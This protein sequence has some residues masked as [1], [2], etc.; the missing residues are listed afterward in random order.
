MRDESGG[1]AAG[2]HAMVP[3]PNDEA[4]LDT[5]LSGWRP[6][7]V[8]WDF[9][10]VLVDTL[11]V[12]AEAWRMLLEARGL[13]FRADRYYAACGRAPEDVALALVNGQMPTPSR[14]WLKEFVQE[15]RVVFFGLL[16]DRTVP[17]LDGVMLWL[18]TIRTAGI[19][20]AIASSTT[21]RIVQAI[22]S[23]LP[24]DRYF[25]AVVTNEDVPAC[26]PAPDVFLEA[27]ARL[28][29]AP[30]GCLVVEDSAHGV[31]AARAAQMKCLAVSCSVGPA[32][33]SCAHV[34]VATLAAADA[35]RLL[36]SFC[37]GA[38]V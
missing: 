10:G 21:Q 30:G 31:Q 38:G 24:V 37:A 32:E 33:L 8:L 36:R 34:T 13:G 29:V 25:S 12:H 22:L 28:G 20:Q 23:G 1:Q 7:A 15:E 19:P 5:G 4:P 27:A 26:K 16:R 3:G 6:K 11:P 17:L 18:E 2:T 14:D 9:D 35:G